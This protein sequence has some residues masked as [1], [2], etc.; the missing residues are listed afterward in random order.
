MK[1]ERPDGW[2][3]TIFQPEDEFSWVLYQCRPDLC[4]YGA[5]QKDCPGEDCNYLATLRPHII[6][7][8]A[9]WVWENRRLVNVYLSSR[10][11]EARIRVRDPE[12]F[13]Y[14]LGIFPT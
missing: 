7:N 6:E 1:F 14:A 3:I 5:T 10:E 4:P 9:A 13:K 2:Y 8:R 11:K 12:A